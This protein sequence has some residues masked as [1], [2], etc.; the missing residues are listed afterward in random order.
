[1]LTTSEPVLAG[2]GAPGRRRGFGRLVLLLQALLAITLLSAGPVPAQSLPGT[3][4]EDEKAAPPADIFGRDTPR[5]LASGLISALAARDYLRASQFLDPDYHPAGAEPGAKPDAEAE[6]EARSAIARRLQDSLDKAGSLLP[7]SMIS[8]DREGAIDDGLP[9]ADERLGAFRVEGEEI[10]LLARRITLEDGAQV[11]VVSGV[12][13]QALPA[14][15]AADIRPPVTTALPEPLR[16]TR[17]AG[18]PVADWL[19]LIA[20][21]AVAYVLSRLVFWLIGFLLKRAV[22]NPKTSRPY[23]I[24]HAASPPVSLYAAVMAVVL[25]SNSL[26]VAIVARQ[27]LI[28]YAAVVGWFAFAWFVWRLI[29]M[30]G[31]AWTQR[32]ARR[33]R[34][35]AM[36]MVTFARRFAKV[37][38]VAVA[39]VAMLDSFGLDI[40]A[41]VAALGLGGLAFALGAQKTVENLVGSIAVISDQPIRVGDFCRVGDVMGTVEDI[42]MRS[43]RIRTNART[44]VSIPNGAFSADQI[45][46]FSSRDKFHFHHVLGLTYDLSAEGME[47]VLEAV[48]EVLREDEHLIDEDAR[49]RFIGFNSS[50]LDIEIFAYVAAADFA[51]YLGY[52][53]ALLLKLMKAVVGAGG[54]F[55]FPTQTLMAKVQTLEAQGTSAGAD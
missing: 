30:L 28:Q 5:G 6:A 20:L 44:V 4:G 52:Q 38:L 15:A 32:M 36:A 50:S 39:A 9:V 43:T 51:E 14:V 21:A 46:N 13:L 42:G 10:P 53:E 25:V 41:G 8:N 17:F 19:L 22:K 35:R 2:R 49:A 33:D 24:F 18:A 29:D 34:R 1:M 45:E 11:W 31:D 12:T 3:K 16:E 40:T 54:E 48:R 23:Q 47:K 26:R 7:F 37:A 27:T 55:A